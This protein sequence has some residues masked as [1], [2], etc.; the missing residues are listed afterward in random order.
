MMKYR[1][2]FLLRLCPA[3]AAMSLCALGC[4]VQP[5]SVPCSNAGDCAAANPRFGYC[6]QSRCVECL[7]DASCGDGGRCKDGLCERPCKRARDCPAGD[8]CS[9]GFCARP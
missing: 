1:L 8:A 4:D 9:D 3:L 6:L 5:K 2:S 7:D